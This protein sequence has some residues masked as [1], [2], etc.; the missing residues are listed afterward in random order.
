MTPPPSL[1]NRCAVLATMHR[2]EH[3][4]APLLEQELGL[5]ITVPPDLD[6]DVFGTFTRDIKRL[7]TQ[8]EAARAKA[9]KAIELTGEPLALASE[10]SFGPHPAVPFLA[11][12]C[13]IVLLL[14]PSQGLELVG[15]AI[16]TDT[17]YS[18]Q[19]VESW[20]EARQF[21]HKVGFPDHGLVVTIGDPM[22]E[23]S[24]IIKGITREEELAEAVQRALHHSPQVHIE[25]DMR[26]LYNPRRM[27]VIQQA[28]EDLLRKITQVCP[29]C[30]WPGFDVVE[31]K[32]GLLCSWCH[33][34][35]QL[36]HAALYRCSYCDF[37]QEKLFPDG[38]HS[39]DPGECAYCNP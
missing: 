4:I 24:Q 19:R 13:E 22:A 35:T 1:R 15:Q 34:P 23:N 14:E 12:N 31:R 11:T 38:R 9:V 25:T 8:I 33:Q 16:S 37:S 30:S 36:T 18:H 2:K 6:T 7:G 27:K 39:A 3:A 32:P 20:E 29:Q 10:G 26:A 28:T 17:N 5:Q 21:A